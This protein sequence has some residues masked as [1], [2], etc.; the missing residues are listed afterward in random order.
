MLA[1]G[2]ETPAELKFLIEENCEAAQGHLLGRPA[3]I[4]AFEEHTHN[5]P[6][7]K[8]NIN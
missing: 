7:T 3:P 1:E 5:M 8:K 2:V 4:T 6:R